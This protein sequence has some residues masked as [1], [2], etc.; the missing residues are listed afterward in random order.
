MLLCACVHG[1]LG[2][3]LPPLGPEDQTQAVRLS[4]RHLN[5]LSRLSCS[6]K[7]LS[8]DVSGLRGTEHKSAIIPHQ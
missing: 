6:A 7:G 1:G 2:S 3:L 8:F 5:S 4:S